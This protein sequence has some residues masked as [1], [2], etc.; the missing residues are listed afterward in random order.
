MFEKWFSFWCSLGIHKW[1]PGQNSGKIQPNLDEEY[2]N[3]RRTD[4]F[5]DFHPSY[6]I[7]THC[8]KEK[9]IEF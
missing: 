9:I 8:G 4:L 3:M 5:C 7:C 1:I 2:M 6:K